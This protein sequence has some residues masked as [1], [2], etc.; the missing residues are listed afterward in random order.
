MIFSRRRDG[1]LIPHLQATRKIMPFLMPTRVESTIYYPQHLRVDNVLAWLE[2]A[3]DGRSKD[4]RYSF[5]H[6]FLTAFARLFRMRP[7]LNR[8]VLGN[9]TYLHDDISFSFTVKQAMT[10]EADE[11]QARIVFTGEETIEQVRR[12]TE[13]AVAEVRS[14]EGNDTDQLLDVL[15][16]LP[17]TILT[18][19]ART[20][21]GLDRLGWLPGFLQDSIPMYAS[22]Y[23]VNL[24]S[25]DGEVPFHHLYQR[26]T[27]SVF[28]AIGSIRKEAVVDEDGQVVARDCV[29]I[30]H[31]IDERVS[32][33]FYFIRS[34]QLLEALIAD[35]DALTRPPTS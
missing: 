10:D 32:D 20:V 17:G 9:R 11:S 35:P 15:A 34:A 18:A 13:R 33:G 27:C 14:G 3:N 16:K 12:M 6:V 19:V 23:V 29:S 24:G 4:E 1:A 31:S 25:I 21:W 30:V 22:A 8:F 2:Q 28:A 5:F 7:E 26:G